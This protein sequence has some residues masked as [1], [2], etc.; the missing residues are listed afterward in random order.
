[1][2]EEYEP[3]IVKNRNG[4]DIK[5]TFDGTNAQA[6]DSKNK[7]VSEFTFSE[8]ED[9]Y[10]PGHYYY[11]LTHMNSYP[12]RQGIGTEI[13]KYVKE[14][15]KSNVTFS[16]DD[17]NSRRDGSHLTGTGPIFVNSLR[18]KKIIPNFN[19]EEEL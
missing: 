17:G 7:L 19:D 9:D 12:P 13:I 5:L 8:R 18:K 2:Y 11:H 16:E 6:F 4:E 15:T 3:K 10:H 14:V 1:M